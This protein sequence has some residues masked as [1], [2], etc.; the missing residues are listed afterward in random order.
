[1]TSGT[2]TP[3]VTA[4]PSPTATFPLPSFTPPPSLVVPTA[5]PTATLIPP[6]ATRTPLPRPAN[7]GQAVGPIPHPDVTVVVDRDG[8]NV[9]LYP[10]IGAEVIATVNAGYSTN[11]LA[12][13]GDNQWVQVEIGGQLGWIG[14]AV[15]AVVNGDLNSAPVAD[16]RTIPYGGFENPR[17]GLTSA[18][19]PFTGKLQNSGLRVRGGPGRAYPVL[20]NAPRYT[21]FPLL[22]RTLN[23]T[24]V[25]V[26]F[27][28]TLGWVAAQFVDFQQGLGVLDQLP[29]DGIVAD[30]LPISEPTG[31]NYID[32]LKLMLS[33]V[34]LA[35]PSLDQIRS[36]WT[37]VA[38]GGRATC[39]SYP[40]RPTDFNIP[41]PILAPYYATLNPLQTDFNA[42]M[43][44]LRQ[45][46]DLLIDAC[47]TPQPPEG[48][49]GQPVVQAALD[50]INAADAS[51]VSLRQ[52]LHGLLPPDQPITDDECL[53]T[54]GDRSEVVPRL[55]INEAQIITLSATHFVKGFC[56]DGGAGQSLSIQALVVSG[57]ARPRLTVSAFDNATNFIG[58][59]QISSGRDDDHH[60]ADPDHADRTLYPDRRGSR[61]RREFRA[62][63]RRHRA[64]ADRQHRRT[65]RGAVGDRPGDG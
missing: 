9:R 47:N 46:I 63:A 13:S 60:L 35:Q 29:I 32:T 14:L 43:A 36:V 5:I 21:I 28:G 16:P 1:M 10:A 49:V 54:F 2:A 31:D 65:G 34:E 25:Q 8:V 33:R 12:R 15:L 50:A 24:W 57:N 4:G 40:A 37:D 27:E 56:F 52:R 62:A 42:A 53:F 41:N 39:G 64:A 7:A 3:T 30:G 6:P 18:T 23:N 38:L 55:R 58:T 11:I 20:A 45:A 44:N 26:N 17:A 22:G 48:L 59:A 19:S 51:F 61:R